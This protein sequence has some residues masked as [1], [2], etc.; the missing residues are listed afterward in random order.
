MKKYLTLVLFFALAFCVQTYI[1]KAQLIKTVVSVTGRVLDEATHGP[2]ATTLEVFDKT[3]N[4]VN[5]VKS[6][7]KDGYYFI[8]GLKPGETY[9]IRNLIDFN[10]KQRYFGQKMTITIPATD[11][12]SEFSHDIVLIPLVKDFKILLRVSPFSTGK[13]K[14]R[15]GSEG[16]LRNYLETLKENQRVKFEILSYPDDNIDGAANLA[17]T[18]ERVAALKEFFVTN[19]INK[20]RI[21]TSGNNALDPQNPPPTGKAAK[22]K[23]Y[24]GS[25]YIVIRTT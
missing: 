5:R 24:K 2:I 18:N 14:L 4:K 8:T 21:S 17:L 19:G 13:S 1:S 6:N 20:D 12:Y 15:A 10:A 9:S 16:I 22:G 23:K 3:G 25:T 7:E 11:K